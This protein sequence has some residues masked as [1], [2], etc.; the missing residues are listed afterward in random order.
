MNLVLWC[1]RVIKIGFYLLF[2]LIPL[3]L[4]PWNYELFEYNKMMVTYALTIII[5]GAWAIK[6]VAQKEMRIAKTP[7]DIP[8]ALFLSSQL[9]S[10]LFSMDPH[11]SWFGYYSRFNGG[12][13]SI[14]SYVLLYYALVSNWPNLSNLTNLLKVALGTAVAVALYGVAERLG[15]DKSL[16]V[17]D[18]QNRVFSTL[19]QP[20]W[21]AAYLVALT[22]IA[23]AM[24]M[25]N[26]KWPMLNK[27][28]KHFLLKYFLFSIFHLAL[29][30]LFFLVL[31]FTRSRSGLLAFA[32]ADI[33]FWSLVFIRPRLAKQGEALRNFLIVHFAFFLI[34][35]LNGTYVDSVDKW[36]TFNAWK[37]RV[38]VQRTN[39]R[40][41]PSTNEAP[42][43]AYTAPLLETGGTQSSVIRKYVWQGAI[44]AWKSSTKTLL[45]GT[46]TETFAYALFAGWISV[47][48]TNFFGFSVVIVQLFLFL[49]P[50]MAIASHQST[51]DSRGLWKT[52]PLK[53][54]PQV[55]KWTSLS[56]LLALFM[57]LFFLGR[58]WW[59]DVLFA[60]GY[61][62]ARNGAYAQAQSLNNQ[63]ITIS[64][65]EPLYH[66][67]YSTTLA[68]LAALAVE[69]KQATLAATMI[70]QALTESD[71]AITISPKN[72]NF[73]KSRTKIFYSFS[74]FDPEFN[75]A[76]ITALT[77][78]WELSPN[79]PKIIYNL[80]ILYGRQNDNTKAIE[81]LQQAINLKPNYRD[82]YFALHVFYKEIGNSQK[83]R[84]VVET[85]LQKVD[86]NDKDFQTRL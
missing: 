66:D 65:A 10:S 13:L 30:I 74:A 7:L 54:T 85:Y 12:M 41:E 37:S 31:L 56:L 2:I 70:G 17:Q 67:E 68:A 6:M 86:P 48:V 64:P 50:A 76:A 53:L 25:L 36:L 63:A 24:G 15:I 55:S 75:P 81:L 3:I 80:A 51:A 27:D 29:V 77:R 79:D 59:A 26:A 28:T 45:I 47:L 33:V 39:E 84:E 69:Q 5:V 61:R 20:N 82:A 16:W 1:N 35:F 49:F 44:N 42:A 18:V 9:L 60:Q 4:T 83:A 23:M 78:A 58:M 43:A 34:V 22:P 32:V 40:A 38:T 11:V 72:V 57:L 19:G 8:I 14:I 52:F 46:G 71:K 73:W 62:L 21:L